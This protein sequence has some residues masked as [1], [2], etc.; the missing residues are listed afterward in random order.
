MPDLIWRKFWRGI[1]PGAPV[2]AILFALLFAAMRAIGTLGPPQWNWVLPLGFVLMALLPWLL[3]TRNGRTQ[4]GLKSANGWRS[5]LVGVAGG[6]AAALLCFSLGTLLYGNSADN[7][8]VSIGNSF[9][10]SLNTA[11]M[12]LL[13]LELFITIPSCLFSPVGEEIFFRGFLQRAMED[14]LSTRGSTVFEA[15]LFALIHLCHH[16]LYVAA[17]GLSI[18]VMSGLIWMS[19]MFFAALLFAWLRRRYDSLFP[20]MAA[21]AAFNF[22]MNTAIFL[23]LW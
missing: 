17:T 15:A 4:I 6:C 7:W 8:F 2:V 11:G 1:L 18:H 12:D 22:T 5:Y 20:A 3:L 10:R 14:R 9:H 16:G 13:T 23:A 19:L 21:H